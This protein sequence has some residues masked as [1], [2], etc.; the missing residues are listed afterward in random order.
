MHA[1]MLTLNGKRMSK[2]TGNTILPSELFNGDNPLLV[3]GFNPSVVRFF[4][5]QAHYSSVLDFSN[6]AFARRGEGTS[7]INE[8][9]GQTAR[10][11]VFKRKYVESSSLAG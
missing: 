5:M 11:F 4:M 3:K 8:C 6:D 1:N 2:S 9:M 7:K 10:A